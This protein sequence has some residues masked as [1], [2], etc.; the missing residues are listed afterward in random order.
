MLLITIGLKI[1][2]R[3]LCVHANDETLKFMNVSL[4]CPRLRRRLYLEA[5]CVFVCY[6]LM[7]ALLGVKMFLNVP[8][9][10]F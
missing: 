2:R 6:F 4:A 10:F 9:L 7:L 8:I 5:G 1:T 3:M